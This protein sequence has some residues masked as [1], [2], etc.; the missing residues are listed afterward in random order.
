LDKVIKEKRAAVSEAGLD[1]QTL[2]H[3]I[4]TLGKERTAAI[5]F[6]TSHEKQYE[7]ILQD[8]E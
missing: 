5:N 1:V 7:W 8:K 3:A 2:E 4:Q 6:V